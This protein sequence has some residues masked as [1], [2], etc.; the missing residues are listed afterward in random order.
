MENENKSVDLGRSRSLVEEYREIKEGVMPLLA[1]GVPETLL[2]AQKDVLRQAILAVARQA[3]TFNPGDMVTLD[4]LRT[5]YA[6]L[7]SFLPYEQALAAADLMR[8]SSLGD[9]SYMNSPEALRA[10]ARAKQIEL[11]AAHLGREF[12][13]FVCKQQSAEFDGIDAYLD[14]LSR[15]YA[16]ADGYGADRAR[17]VRTEPVAT[18]SV[19]RAVK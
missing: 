19:A 2:P 18:P 17:R 12:D 10:L 3:C 11:E 4:R 16:P 6:S 13:R 7:A 1:T 15:K 8:A 9:R 14:S 5:C